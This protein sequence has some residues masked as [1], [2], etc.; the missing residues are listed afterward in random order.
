MK[1]IKFKYSGDNAES[2]TYKPQNF[3]NSF[4]QIC[5][6]KDESTNLYMTRKIIYNERYDILKIFEKKYDA[7]TIEKFLKNTNINK[8]KL[9]PVNN[10]SYL[11]I[12]NVSDFMNANS[13]LSN[14]KP[15]TNDM[16]CYDSYN[17][18]MFGKMPNSNIMAFVGN[19]ISNQKKKIGNIDDSN[20][21]NGAPNNKNLI[22]I[23]NNLV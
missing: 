16:N 11:E 6:F 14:N 15:K 5:Q 4:Y 21:Y 22:M 10:I 1:N 2:L 17:D 19:D 20:F 7:K 18:L 9:Y 8:Y 3:Q 23:N 13:E 12:P